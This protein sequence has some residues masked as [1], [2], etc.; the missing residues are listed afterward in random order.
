[1]ATTL[2]CISRYILAL[3][4]N[5][6]AHQNKMHA[7]GNATLWPVIDIGCNIGIQP[8]GSQSRIPSGEQDLIG[9]LMI[10]ASAQVSS[11]LLY[12]KFIHPS[13]LA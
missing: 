12:P 3:L 6:C 1:M 10:I 13:L 4:H 7:A 2:P 9:C 5:K 8:L 11:I